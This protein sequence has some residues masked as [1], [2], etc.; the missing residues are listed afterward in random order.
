M[1]QRL[2]LRQPATRHYRDFAETLWRR[3]H[4]GLYEFCHKGRKPSIA[5]SP[6]AQRGSRPAFPGPIPPSA[7]AGRPARRASAAQRSGPSPLAPGWLRVGKTG[8]TSTASARSR[9]ARASPRRPCTAA[10]SSSPRP[11]RA[12]RKG[13]SPAT[14]SR[15]GRCSPAPSRSASRP[16]PPMIRPACLARTIPASP[17]STPGATPRAS[18]APPGGRRAASARGSGSRN[19]SLTSTSRGPAHGLSRR[20]AASSLPIA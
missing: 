12:R 20:A 11:R 13:S 3:R 2:K 1:G 9:L 6:A 4:S 8:E 14:P 10:V 19:G 17:S 16:S 18:T 5:A 7:I 15:S